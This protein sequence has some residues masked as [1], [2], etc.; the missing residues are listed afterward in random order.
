M[1]ALAMVGLAGFS[2][3]ALATN[4]SVS[5]GDLIL[6]IYA[7][8]GQGSGTTYYTDLGAIT[9]FTN[10]E[11]DLSGRV[12]ETDLSTLFGSNLANTNYFVIG[13][14]GAQTTVGTLTLNTHAVL[15]TNTAPAATSQS[16][17]STADSTINM[18]YTAANGAVTANS[19][20]STEVVQAYTSIPGITSNFSLG[21]TNSVA[22]ANNAVAQYDYL[23]PN[24]NNQVFPASSATGTEANV[25]TFQFVGGNDFYYDYTASVPEPSTYALFGLG[26]GAL[27]VVINARRRLVA[28]V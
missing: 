16:T 1:A 26:A 3:S 9:G 28:K 12:N 24:G 19:N 6:G 23:N 11:V 14:L 17:L 21:G 20:F 2:Q 10:T 27:F 25:G 8:S 4:V 18:L 13:Y 5:T 22:E 15:S 7:T